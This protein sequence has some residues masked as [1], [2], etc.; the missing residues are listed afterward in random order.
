MPTTQS[1]TQQQQLQAQQPRQKARSRRGARDCCLLAVAPQLPALV[2]VVDGLHE[3]T[4]CARLAC[5]PQGLYR[6]DE[7]RPN[8]I[9]FDKRVVRGNTYAARPLPGE[10]QP[11]IA[12]RQAL[13]GMRVA[14]RAGPLCLLSGAACTRATARAMPVD[15]PPPPSGSLLRCTLRPTH[16]P[17]AY[18]RGTQ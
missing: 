11:S 9:M 10:M 8:N 6:E 12:Q 5:A 13:G 1:R 17:R 4:V 3:P 14:A 18:A 7:P 2:C 16:P 15:A